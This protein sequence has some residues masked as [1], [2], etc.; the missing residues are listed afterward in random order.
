MTII[1]SN[2]K[3]GYTCHAWKLRKCGHFSES[4]ENKTNLLLSHFH[5]HMPCRKAVPVRKIQLNKK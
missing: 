1:A 4:D 3:E 2:K 5:R